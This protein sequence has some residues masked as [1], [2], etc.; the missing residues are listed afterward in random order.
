MVAD[1]PTGAEAILR[2]RALKTSAD[3]DDCWLIGAIG[4]PWRM[5]Q[6]R[7]RGT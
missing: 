1:R 5:A 2:L 6:Q 3:F 7:A 4:R